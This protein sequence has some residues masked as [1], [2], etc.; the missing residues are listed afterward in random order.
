MDFDKEKYDV[1]RIPFSEAKEWVMY[2]HYLHRI[3]SICYAFGLYGPIDQDG[4]IS[5]VGVCTFGI[6][7]SPSLV[8]ASVG[9][10]YR[11]TFIELNRLCVNEGLPRN[12]L[13]FFVSHCLQMLPRPMVVISY[14]DS[15]MGHHGYIY[16]AT[17]WVYTGMSSKSTEYS[18][19][20][21]EEKHSRH[22]RDRVKTE[23]GETIYD[24]LVKM[25]GSDRVIRKEGSRKYRYF[26]FLG[27][28]RQVR[29]MKKDL[30][31]PIIPEYP[32]GEND[33]YDASYETSP[34]GV[35]F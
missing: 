26:Q 30:K 6:P 20:G 4:T 33:R 31:F 23:V 35:L 16:Q 32:K 12:A 22:L 18:V 14:A 19:E 17:N 27:D 8:E 5:L 10:Q 9:E 29:Q 25:Y 1:R 2:K 34:N 7:P 11:D 15:G 24:A 13:S 21:M 3:P 28:K